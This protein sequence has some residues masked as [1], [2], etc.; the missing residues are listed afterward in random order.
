M[1]SKHGMLLAAMFGMLGMDFGPPVEKTPK[2]HTK[3]VFTDEELALVRSLPKKERKALVAEL[4][5]KYANKG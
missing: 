5:R 4:R 2:S 3:P 1:K